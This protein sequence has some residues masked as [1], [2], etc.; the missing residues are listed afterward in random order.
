VSKGATT[1]EFQ[2]DRVLREE[3]TNE[4]LF[5]DEVA[6][7]V[8]GCF[9]G[10]NA[11]VL[12]YGQSGSGKTYTMGT[13][14][15]TLHSHQEGIIPRALKALFAHID[16]GDAS[17]QQQFKVAVSFLEIY[18]EEFIDLLGQCKAE[19][20]VRENADNGT[21]TSGLTELSVG[22]VSEACDLLERGTQARKTAGTLMNAVSSRSHAVFT[23]SIERQHH[24]HRYCSKLHLVDLAGSERSKRTG[25]VGVRLRESVGINQGLMSLGRVI[26]A[27]SDKPSASK[28]VPYRDSKV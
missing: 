8:D 11:T 1:K 13:T 25:A 23:V 22:S 5:L 24:H 6:A 26:R 9:Q 20:L 28:H 27:L 12:A 7:V 14:T 3:C 10:Y 15:A 21:V 19:I 16:G 18:N 4:Q 17:S 2:F